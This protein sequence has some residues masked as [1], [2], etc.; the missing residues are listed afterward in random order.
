MSKDDQDALLEKIRQ[1]IAT[2]WQ[3]SPHEEWLLND[4][5]LDI[6]EAFDERFAKVE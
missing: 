6:K 2:H 4:S 1:I 3:S 5:M